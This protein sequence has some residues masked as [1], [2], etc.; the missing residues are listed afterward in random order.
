MF[1]Y[2]LIEFKFQNSFVEPPHPLFTVFLASTK[3]ILDFLPCVHCFGLFSVSLLE[4]FEQISLVIFEYPDCKN[5]LSFR[6]FFISFGVICID[7]S[8]MLPLNHSLIHH[9]LDKAESTCNWLY[10]HCGSCQ[11]WELHLRTFNASEMPVC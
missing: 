9:W 6:A 5:V 10:I 4:D 11:E 7:D 3:H 1:L 2:R 8:G